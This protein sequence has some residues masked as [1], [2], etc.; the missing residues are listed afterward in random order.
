MYTIQNSYSSGWDMHSSVA[1]SFMLEERDAAGGGAVA[2][3][4]RAAGVLLLVLE[5]LGAQALAELRQ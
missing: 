5:A 3:R 2:D 4:A 1:C